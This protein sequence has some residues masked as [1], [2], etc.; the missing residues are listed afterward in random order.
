MRQ[1][2]RIG[3]YG[4]CRD[5]AGRVLMARSSAKASV[6]GVWQI[7]GGGVDHGEGPLEALVREFAEETG[8]SVAV[9][10]LF[11]VR[12]SLVEMPERDQLVHHDRIVF[13]VTASGGELRAETAGTTD[14]VRWFAPDELVGLPML[15][16]VTR[17]LG[18]GVAVGGEPG[19]WASAVAGS[20]PVVART[21]VTH[22][23]RFAAYGLTRDL[24]DRILL[25]RIAHGY[26]GAGSWHLPGG[27][28]DFGESAAEGLARE[29][30]EETGQ[31]G[32]VGELLS[33]THFHNP[34]A[35]GP[36]KRPIDW[37]TVRT[38]FRVIVTT[39]TEPIV[40]ERD[41]STDMAAWFSL[42][43]ARK[44]NLNKLAQRVITDYAT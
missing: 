41:G 21:P 23:Q 2:R 42:V 24:A 5:E 3:V 35:Y 27:G 28:T 10:R 34:V 44:L 38:V 39:P 12:S 26:P 32:D 33:V 17:L 7:P 11:G 4:I 16:W 43:E 20:T 36:E 31:Q 1:R 8:L 19:D 9:T 30:A 15:P 40:H 37:H 18:A 13:E 22:V 6:A 25:T 29:L 14:A